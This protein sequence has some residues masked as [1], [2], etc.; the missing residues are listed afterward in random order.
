MTFPDQPSSKPKVPK[1]I[2]KTEPKKQVGIPVPVGD[3]PKIQHEHLIK[4]AAE[5]YSEKLQL[6]IDPKVLD[7]II[8]NCAK[9][10]VKKLQGLTIF[11]KT[12]LDIRYFFAFTAIVC[13]GLGAGFGGVYELLN[14]IFGDIPKK[15]DFL[16]IKSP[17]FIGAGL[18]LVAGVSLN[19]ILRIIDFFYEGIFKLLIGK[20]TIQNMLEKLAKDRKI[21]EA[22]QVNLLEFIRLKVVSLLEENA[23][24]DGFSLEKLVESYKKAK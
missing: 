8:A 24:P 19:V 15:L 1:W 17:L 7:M 11:E 6:E 9:M 20:S 10:D 3:L 4:E 5:F 21:K 16:Q 22:K 23:I 14:Q 13:A 12:K 2:I 18:G